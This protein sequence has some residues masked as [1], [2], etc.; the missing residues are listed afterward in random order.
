MSTE[1][2]REA[3]REA[4]D[5]AEEYDQYAVVQ[6]GVAEDLAQKLSTLYLVDNPKIL[7]IGCGTGYLVEAMMERG[8]YGDYLVTDVSPAM[9][10]RTRAKIG[11]GSDIS[12]AVLD[13]E[14]GEPEGGPFDIV[15]SNLTLQW[16]DDPRTAIGRMLEWVAP[17]GHLVVTILTSGTF[18]EWRKACEAEGVE[19]GIPK[20]PEPADL[21]DWYP[22]YWAMPP[23]GHRYARIYKNGINFLRS[24]HGLG[25]NTPK[26]GYTPMKPSVLRRVFRHYETPNAKSTYDVVTL[27]YTVP[28]DAE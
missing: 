24:L 3:V 25:A 28:F 2:R 23:K 5:A 19:P 11:E 22:H 4:F 26:E 12:Y 7:E 10:E 15:C 9:V 6:H 16:F 8:I 17:G 1:T 21:G 20:F 14:Y 18:A 13:G 27:H